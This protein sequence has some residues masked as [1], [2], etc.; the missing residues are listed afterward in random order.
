MKLEKIIGMKNQIELSCLTDL[1]SH[2][3]V[4]GRM[5]TDSTIF[6]GKRID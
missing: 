2:A 1:L 5:S 3:Q 4:L 6:L